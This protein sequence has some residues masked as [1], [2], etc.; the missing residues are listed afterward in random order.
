MIQRPYFLDKI[1]AMKDTSTIKVITGIRRCGKSTLLRDLY[2]AWLIQQGIKSD[3]ILNFDLEDKKNL[4]LRQSSVLFEEIKK[5]T[6]SIDKY[7]LF[8]DE[9]QHLDEKKDGTPDPRRMADALN[10]LAK[11]TNFD[12]YVTGSNS[13][14]LS[15]NVAT[16]LADRGFEIQIYPLRF[17][18]YLSASSLSPEE[19]L[20]RYFIYGGMP[21]LFQLPDDEAKAA[22]LEHLV[23]SVYFKDV[24][25]RYRLRK[26]HTLEKLMETLASNIGSRSSTTKLEAVLASS[27]IKIT[28]DTIQKYFTYLTDAF[29]FEKANRYDVKGNNCLRGLE[30]YYAEDLGLR[31]AQLGFRQLEENHLMENLIYLELKI[32]GYQVDVGSVNDSSNNGKTYEVDFVCRKGANQIYIQSVLDMS[33]AEKAAKEQKPFHEINNGYRK[34]FIQRAKPLS[35]YTEDGYLVLG[36]LEFLLDDDALTKSYLV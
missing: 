31:N 27:G 3:H 1:I 6:N 33:S 2:G 13:R 18:E 5:R 21:F 12:V 28:D 19:A 4:S 17:Q 30:K 11:P 16:E 35:H 9:A 20:S 10:G 14:F 29:L 24:K 22:Y 7:Y 23:S 8:I 34:V 25:D 32:R 36:L 15:K 26:S